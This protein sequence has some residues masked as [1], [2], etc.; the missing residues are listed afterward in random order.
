MPVPSSC[1]A[2]TLR[3]ID[4]T[5]CES[6]RSID[7][8]RSCVQLRCLWMPLC[9]S[10]SDLSP[11]GSL[12]SETLEELWMAYSLGV[13]SLAYSLGVVSLA[14]CTRLRK[15]DLR[16]CSSADLN[17]VEGLK[18]TCTKLAD[19]RSV[20]LDGLAHELQTN[21]PPNMQR[22]AADELWCLADH[23]TQNLSAIIPALEQLLLESDSPSVRVAAEGA[24][25]A[26]SPSVVFPTGGGGGWA[27]AA[28]AGTPAGQALPMAV[29]HVVH[30]SG[31]YRAAVAA[32]AAAPAASST[33]DVPLARRLSDMTL[34]AGRPPERQPGSSEGRG[35]GAAG[36][37]GSGVC[38]I[39][40]LSHTRPAPREYA[41]RPAAAAPSLHEW[42]APAGNAQHHQ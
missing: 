41:P 2:T 25:R 39:M 10:V 38:T 34:A 12:C 23:G 27:G 20:E 13:V 28:T 21:M 9:C 15:L 7:F 26:A 31:A 32:A 18:L 35:A 4:I 3:V 16:G 8:V 24:L 30:G 6:L 11:L 33:D 40:R 22:Q 1:V 36:S 17:Q 42:V 14:A 37:A 19:P 29:V 5:G